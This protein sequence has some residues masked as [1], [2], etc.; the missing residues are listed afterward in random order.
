MVTMGVPECLRKILMK[1]VVRNILF[2]IKHDCGED[3]DGHGEREE[4]EA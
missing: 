4:K 3:N 2:C 1:F